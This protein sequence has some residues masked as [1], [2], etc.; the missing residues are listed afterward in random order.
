MTETVT[1]RVHRKRDALGAHPLRGRIQLVLGKNGGSAAGR[2][3]HGLR[4]GATAT[5]SLG[6]VAE[7]LLVTIRLHALFALMLTDF[8]LTTFF[9][10]AHC[11]CWLVGLF[12]R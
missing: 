4:Q 2:H 1:P 8:C 9:E 6:L 7:A 3:G 10:T 12:M 5:R 11:G